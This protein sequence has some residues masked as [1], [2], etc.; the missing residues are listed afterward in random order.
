MHTTCALIDAQVLALAVPVLFIVEDNTNASFFI[1]AG[2]IFLN[3]FTTQ[4]FIFV[5]KILA[6]NFPW[7]ADNSTGL[8][9]SSSSV[10][11][12]VR[13]SNAAEKVVAASS[14]ER[15]QSTDSS[16]AS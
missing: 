16:S 2:V 4:C 14:S 13:F 9:S 7:L 10:S 12:S 6:A 11:P 15:R 3:D 5:P 1:R 8:S